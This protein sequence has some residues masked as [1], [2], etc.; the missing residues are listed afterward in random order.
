MVSKLLSILNRI[1]N[2]DKIVHMGFGAI[3]ALSP[4]YP[5]EAILV[6]AFGKEVYDYFHPN[7]HTCDGM[8]AIATIVG[9]FV[10]LTFLGN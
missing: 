4:W 1:Q 2:W 7:K 10:M 8:D 5:L 9:G 3:A 6:V